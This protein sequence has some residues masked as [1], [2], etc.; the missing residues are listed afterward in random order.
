MT[1]RVIPGTVG[2]NAGGERLRRT[3]GVHV[4]NGKLWTLWQRWTDSKG[5]V[6]GG[7]KRV[8]TAPE[9]VIKRAEPGLVAFGKEKAVEGHEVKA[10]P[11]DKLPDP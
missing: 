4:G 7:W 11:F 2:G 8:H 1:R 5:D 10:L 3:E 6:P 9:A